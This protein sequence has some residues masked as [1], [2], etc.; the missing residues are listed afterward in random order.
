MPPYHALLNTATNSSGEA[1]GVSGHTNRV[2]PAAS[3][4]LTQAK[5][6]WDI[7]RDLI[8]KP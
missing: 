8:G 3:S 6:Y 1:A 5:P 7:A 4:T 2:N